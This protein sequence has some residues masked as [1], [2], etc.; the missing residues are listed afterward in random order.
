MRAVVTGYMRAHQ[1]EL[2]S[3]LPEG[4]TI[5]TFIRSQVEPMY[6]DADSL[7]CMALA[8]A[9]AVGVQIEY[10]DPREGPLN[11]HNFP[12]NAEPKVFLLYRPGHYDVLYPKTSS[13]TDSSSSS[14][15]SS[16]ASSSTSTSSTSSISSTSS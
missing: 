13:S 7:Q 3:Y 1:D 10:L 6:T 12:E 16:T 2:S 4:Q 15:L 8:S 5:E 9:L 11:H 14:T